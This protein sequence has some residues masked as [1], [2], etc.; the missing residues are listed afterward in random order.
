VR[1]GGAVGGR[2]ARK[3][4]RIGVWGRRPQR[5]ESLPRAKAGGRALA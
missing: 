3:A 1:A 2:V 4:L 5:V